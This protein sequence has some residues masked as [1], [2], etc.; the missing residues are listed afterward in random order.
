M[1]L[2]LFVVLAQ[3]TF[4][5]EVRAGQP[6][7]VNGAVRRVLPREIGNWEW[8][9]APDQRFGFK[10][11]GGTTVRRALRPPSTW[12]YDDIAQF[13]G[14]RSVVHINIDKA[15]QAFLKDPKLKGLWSKAATDSSIG[16]KPLDE[17]VAPSGVAPKYALGI[18]GLRH[19]SASSNPYMTQVL[20]RFD[21]QPKLKAT[22]VQE[23]AFHRTLENNAY[24]SVPRIAKLGSKLFVLGKTGIQEYTAAGLGKVV[25]PIEK[26]EAPIGQVGQVGYAFLNQAKEIRIW[27]PGKPDRTL[28][29]PPATEY[30]EPRVDRGSSLIVYGRNVIDAATGKQWQIPSEFWKVPPP[31]EGQVQPTI[32]WQNY[33]IR[34]D[35]KTAVV[36]DGRTGKRLASASRPR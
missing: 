2:S 33:A 26:G 34:W 3:P 32:V 28:T 13:R 21:V 29:L 31:Q 16:P 9:L 24:F 19:S 8:D 10:A 27:S 6:W 7:L 25:E 1:L 18:V 15:M 4:K 12:Q 35:G 22:V 5:V 20:V 17:L 23:I 11:A 14:S 36:F 30:T